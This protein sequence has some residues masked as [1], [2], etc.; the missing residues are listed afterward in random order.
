M[1]LA[2]TSAAVALAGALALSAAVHAQTANTTDP[3]AVQA[4]T[5]A[6]ETKHARVLFAVSHFGFST[7]YGDFTGATGTLKLDPK[8]PS[9]SRLEVSIPTASVSTTNA[10]LDGELKSAD[11]FDA[12]KHPTI[13]FRSTAVTPTGPST[14][15]VAGDLTFHGVTKPV[16]L[17]ATFKA[18]GTNPM[19]KAYTV[20]FEVTGRI[21][22]SDFGVT[23]YVP[24]VG[25]EVDL[26]IS[27]P[28]ERT[29]G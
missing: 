24:A 14:A 22:R 7:W 29:G 10:T 23:T 17:D 11:W 19:N 20:G 15:K 26:I 12:A 8:S 21:K 2:H 28:F 27:A 3:A 6:L 18:A 9:A 5:Y 13:T 1:T 16:V 4:G 25:D